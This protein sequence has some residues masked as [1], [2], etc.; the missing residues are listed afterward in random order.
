MWNRSSHIGN[1]NPFMISDMTDRHFDKLV[2][3][4]LFLAILAAI[5]FHRGLDVATQQ[6]LLAMFSGM[7]G[8]IIALMTGSR[9]TPRKND[10][11]SNAL[12]GK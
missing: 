3:T 1:T 8:A 12:G 5:I 7:G 4:L 2:L 9:N 11:T 6:A 10:D